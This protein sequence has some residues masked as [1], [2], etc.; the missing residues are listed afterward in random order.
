MRRAGLLL[1]FLSCWVFCLLAPVGAQESTTP[2]EDQYDGSSDGESCEGAVEVASVGPKTENTVTPFET[3]GRTFLVSY[4]VQFEDPQAFNLVEID[5]E[6]RFGLVDFENVEENETNSFVVTEGAGSYELVVNAKPANGATYTVTVEDC[7]G[8]TD[9][10]GTTGGSGEQPGPVD[11]PKG[12]KQGTSSSKE[13]PFTGGP[14]YLAFGA[15]ALLG[16]ALLV[17]RGVLKR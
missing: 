3:T 8:T 14:P 9:G 12:V 6:D 17:G 13:I 11:S 4:D 2:A 15:L 7:V 16:G 10:D 5:I 1:M